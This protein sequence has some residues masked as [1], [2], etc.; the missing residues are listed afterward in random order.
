MAAEE[1]TEGLLHKYNVARVS[2]PTGKHDNC[3]YFVLDPKHDPI[4]R[5]ALSSYAARARLDGYEELYQDLMD[6]LLELDRLDE[7]VALE[8]RLN[9]LRNFGDKND[10]L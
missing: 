9:T 7:A 2:D 10:N 4:A 8:N 5:Q 6:W 3:R 1:K